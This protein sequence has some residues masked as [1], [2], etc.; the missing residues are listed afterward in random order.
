MRRTD[1]DWQRWAAHD[2]VAVTY[3]VQDG[4]ILLIHKKRGLGAGKVNAPGGRLEPGETAPDAA[5]RE[6]E[7]E[8]GLRLTGDLVPVAEHR[9]QFVD[10]LRLHL[11]GFLA[12]GAT[13]TLIE[14]EEAR[15]FWCSQSEIPYPQLWAD[16]RLWLPPV[17]DGA[18][19]EG[20]FV[21]D[22]DAMTDF[23]LRLCARAR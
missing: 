19:A 15:P 20:T 10:G 5:V 13:G 23:D 17:L 7:E 6:F 1:I 11:H 3:L 16:N 14:T 4:Q 12:L 2:V 21:F 18:F 9:Y 22:D 8:V